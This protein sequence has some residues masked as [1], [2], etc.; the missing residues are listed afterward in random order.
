MRGELHCGERATIRNLAR[1]QLA[2]S[3][4]VCW[5]LFHLQF[6]DTVVFT[7]QNAVHCTVFTRHRL[8][9]YVI[10][11][12][13]SVRGERCIKING[14]VFCKQ[15]GVCVLPRAFS[16]SAIDKAVVRYQIKRRG[17]TANIVAEIVVQCAFVIA[18]PGK[19]Y[20][21]RLIV[22]NCD[23]LVGY[24]VSRYRANR[25]AAS[26][27]KITVFIFFVKGSGNVGQRCLA[28]IFEVQRHTR[29]I[30]F[31]ALPL[32]FVKCM[33]LIRFLVDIHFPGDFIY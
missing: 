1:P 30:V 8:L 22:R 19:L 6:F 3:A 33:S 12:C 21:L 5:Y 17:F 31:H 16:T 24:G 25:L 18:R 20:K 32:G 4:I 23:F 9:A 10:V 29:V 13:I 2:V 26:Y 28:C 11:P 27:Y 7:R 15:I 14:L